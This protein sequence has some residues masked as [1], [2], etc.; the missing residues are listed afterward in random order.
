[1]ST[2]GKAFTKLYT[3]TKLGSEDVIALIE[4]NDGAQNLD[5]SGKDL[6]GI[7][8]DRRTLSQLRCTGNSMVQGLPVWQ[9]QQTGGINLQG[10]N[11]AW[12]VLS[13]AD[14]S[15]GCLRGAD[16]RGARLDRADLIDTDLQDAILWDTNLNNAILDGANLR[17][18]NIFGA[19]ILNATLSKE[20]FG[21]SIIQESKDYQPP[22][23][24]TMLPERNRFWQGSKIY[25]TLKIGFESEGSYGDA[26]WAYRRARRMEKHLAADYARYSWRKKDYRN[27][28]KNVVKRVSD[29]V[30]EK[31]CD[32]GE[33]WMLVLLWISVV[34]LSFALLYGLL[35]G[36]QRLNPGGMSRTTYNLVDLLA[37]SLATMTTIEPVGLGVRNIGIMRILMPLEALVGIALTGLFGFV[38]GNRI[39]RV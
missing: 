27:F 21:D 15:E 39:N 36:V 17:G 24:I 13:G 19:N 35:G 1:M 37:F 16:L 12:A 14:L 11:L 33:N 32:Y 18:A 4:E 8:L 9:Y 5:L 30:V 3:D 28:V 20:C 2:V 10:A 22:P 6:S 23:G 31:L 25:R 7:K 34:W 26:S 38:L 29:E